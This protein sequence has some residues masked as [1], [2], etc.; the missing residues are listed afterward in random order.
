MKKRFLMAYSMGKDSTLALQKMINMG[1]EPAALLVG[2]YKNSDHTIVHHVP[3]DKLHRFADSLNVPIELVSLHIND[4]WTSAMRA[5]IKLKE[6]YDTDL[7]V[8]GDID[9]PRHIERN[10]RFAELIGLNLFMP[11]SEMTREECVKEQ[12]ANHYKCIITTI[13]ASKLPDSLLGQELTYDVIETIKSY[14]CDA[15]GENSEYHTLVVDSPLHR[16]PIKY[17]LKD[18]VI[19]E[20]RH[21]QTFD[22]E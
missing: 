3:L 17:H 7:Y 19:D 5:G 2:Y 10:K 21:E 8:T 4:D 1:Y 12:L 13:D 6:K 20:F 18:I 9:H 14:G 15:C 22:I 11:L 16:Y